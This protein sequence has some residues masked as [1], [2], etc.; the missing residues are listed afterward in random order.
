MRVIFEVPSYRLKPRILLERR[1]LQSCG[2]KPQ[3][4][5]PRRR[6]RRLPSH[7]RRRLRV[8]TR[9]PSLLGAW[10]RTRHHQGGTTLSSSVARRFTECQGRTEEP[11]VPPRRS[12]RSSAPPPYTPW[13]SAYGFIILSKEEEKKFS[14]LEK[15]L[16]ETSISTIKLSTHW[17][18]AQTYIICW[19]T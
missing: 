9:F 2:R 15:R 6:G 4:S 19:G 13:Y 18:L 12:A 5:S 17:V 10:R 11:P 16:V 14:R 8:G 7:I 3:V 1:V